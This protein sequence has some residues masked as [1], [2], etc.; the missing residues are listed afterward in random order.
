VFRDNGYQ[1]IR[2]LEPQDHWQEVTVATPSQSHFCG[3]EQFGLEVY[4]ILG[5][6][7]ISS[8]RD[9]SSDDFTAPQAITPGASVQR[10]ASAI[11][12]AYWGS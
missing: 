5:G 10:A 3:K 12:V 8:W 4:Q 2:D 6:C 1:L 9:G 11:S 7:F